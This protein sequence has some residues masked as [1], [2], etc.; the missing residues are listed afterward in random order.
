[1]EQPELAA[2]LVLQLVADVHVLVR[3]ANVELERLH[4]RADAVALDA[5]QPPH[6]ARVDRRRAHPLVDRDRVDLR[7]A[8]RRDRD[9]RHQRAV[10]EMA[11]M[12]ALE[13]DRQQPLARQG[14]ERGPV[15]THGGSPPLMASGRTLSRFTLRLQCIWRSVQAERRSAEFVE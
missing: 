7:H 15:E 12:H 3:E 11:H 5:H 2:A 14:F 4:D 1:V 8:A 13:R 9:L 10:E 6:A